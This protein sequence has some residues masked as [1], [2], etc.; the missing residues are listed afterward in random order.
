MTDLVDRLKT[1]YGIFVEHL[2]QLPLGADMNA[3]V[4]MAVTDDGTSY[5]IKQK[6]HQDVSLL[7]F[8]EASGIQQIIAPLKQI[9]ND[10]TVYPFVEG[11][12]GFSQPL[13]D[14]Q[15]IS[16]GKT[17]KQIH[18]LTVPQAIQDHIRKETYSPKWRE[19]IRSFNLKER[20]SLVNRMVDRAEQLSQKVQKMSPKFVLCHSDIHGGNVLM[21]KNGS[22]FIVDWD[23]PI[24]APK[25]RDLM[26]IGGGVANVWNDPRE[27]ELFYQGYGKSEINRE[28]LSYY[29]YERIIQDIAEY[30]QAAP[31]TAEMYKH[32]LDMFEPNGVVDIAFK[33]DQQ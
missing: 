28:I 5:F 33:T 23:E 15:W 22:I 16:L 6:Q 31:M 21:D 20:Q 30:S 25:E 27:E 10:L 29:R 8:L 1:K 26:F 18:E 3:T 4:Y 12:N 7:I 32:F 17:L 11:E 2:T 24:M 14:E 19:A 9:D 13:N